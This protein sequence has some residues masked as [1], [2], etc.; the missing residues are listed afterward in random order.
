MKNAWNYE[1]TVAEIE[2][3]ISQIESGTLPL[4]DVFENFAIAVEQLRQCEAFL[5]E[6]KQR[7][8][9]LIETLGQI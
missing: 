7:M 8:N 2:Q 9:L 5:N 1:V 4:E 3:I 6:G